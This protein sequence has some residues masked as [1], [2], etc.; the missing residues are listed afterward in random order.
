M[1]PKHT[2]TMEKSNLALLFVTVTALVLAENAS[3]LYKTVKEHSK[4]T[5]T[6]K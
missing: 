2:I 6:M 4:C 5:K 3:G 1:I